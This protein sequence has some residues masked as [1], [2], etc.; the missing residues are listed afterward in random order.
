MSGLDATEL[1]DVL[2]ESTSPEGTGEFVLLGMPD[3][4]GYLRGKALRRD[5]FESAVEQGTVMTD[6]LLALDPVDAPITDYEQFGIRSGAGDLLVRPDVETMRELTWRPGWSICLTTPHW[7]DGSRCGLASREVLRDAFAAAAEVGYD[8]M[9]A[10]EYEVRL[11]DAGEQPLSSGIS[12]SLI[13]VGRFEEFVGRLSSALAGLG[14]DLSAIHTEAGPGLLELNLVAR[15]GLR[16]AD[17]A[18]LVKFAVKDVASTL[19]LRASFLAKTVAGEEGS[20]GHVHVSFWSDGA[21][22]FAPENGELPQTATA[23][24]AGMLEHLPGAS[25]LLNPTINS[26]KRLVPGWFAPVNAS[27]GIENRSCA[28]RAIASTEPERCRVECRRPGA[29]ANPYLALAALV[30]SALDGIRRG[31]APP[32]PVEGDAYSREDLP[33]LPGSLESALGAFRADDGLR[34]ALGETFSEYF[35]VSREWE[36]RA[37]RESVSDWERERYERAV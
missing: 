9:A 12:Y 10:L 16:A 18:A 29:D 25:L 31:T 27:W 33:A 3:V 6:L 30:V 28:I 4:N 15:T 14:I 37:W 5:A 24:I 7:R 13:E 26:Y 1:A 34:R 19:G 22:A 2:A 20:S 8:V 21:N 23:A 32:A 17:D 11:R 36:L 35:A